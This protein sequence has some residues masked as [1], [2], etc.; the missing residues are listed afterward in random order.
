MPSLCSDP[1]EF[2]AD[3]LTRLIELLR[4]RDGYTWELLTKGTLGREGIIE[5]D[6]CYLELFV[7]SDLPYQ[8]YIREVEAP[9]TQPNF[10][11]RGI[12]LQAILQGRSSLDRE[13]V[14]GSIVLRAH[15]PDLLRIYQ[16]FVSIL[17]DTPIDSRLRLLYREWEEQWPYLETPAALVP[18]EKQAPEFDLFISRIPYA[19]RTMEDFISNGDS[20]PKR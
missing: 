16:L 10:S 11:S 9:L 6:G 17:A 19:I 12:F 4:A 2:L 15:L 13:I 18:L 14:E 8:L 5:L 20:R 1:A 7:E 3:L